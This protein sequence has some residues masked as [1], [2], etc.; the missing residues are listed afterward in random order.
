MILVI[1]SLLLTFA[2]S[3]LFDKGYRPQPLE[4]VAEPRLDTTARRGILVIQGCGKD[5]EDQLSAIE[6]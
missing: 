3:G 4:R 6:D 1:L 5:Q 2:D